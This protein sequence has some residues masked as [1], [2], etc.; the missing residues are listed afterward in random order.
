M[1]DKLAKDLVP[2][3]KVLGPFWERIVESVQVNESTIAD[4]PMTTTGA[5]RWP[6]VKVTYANGSTSTYRADAFVEVGD[7]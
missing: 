1:S 7:D 2:G 4:D 6:G 5:G 3:D